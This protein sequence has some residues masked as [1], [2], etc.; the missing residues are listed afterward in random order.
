VGHVSTS[1]DPTPLDRNRVDPNRLDPLLTDVD[2]ILFDM[3]GVL[4]D[5]ESLYTEATRRIL[6]PLADRFDFRL[7]EK[8]MGRAPQIAAK[9]LLEGVG[10][11]MS[12]EEWNE[13]KGPVLLELFRQSAPKPGAPE[14]VSELKRRGL[15][16]A[17][18]TSSDRKFLEAKTSHHAWFQF[19]A[20]V[21]ASD[22]E[23]S[24]HKPAPDVFLEA[25]RRIGVPPTRCLVFEDSIAGVEAARRA[26]VGRIVAIV[27]PLLDKKQVRAAHL[28]IES[29][30]EL[31]FEPL[32]LES[33]GPVP[34]EL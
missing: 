10:S 4:L 32:N 21:C 18:A 20:V 27:D 25:A 12:I 16:I 23:V 6:G 13:K 15:P 11:T 26:R 34:H 17:V 8:M 14:L 33:R 29:Y 19:S 31:G 3:D 2:G 1:F 30:T 7:K 22:P 9:I 28:I 5:T 24:R